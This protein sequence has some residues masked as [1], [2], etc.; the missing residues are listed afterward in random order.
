MRAADPVYR[1]RRFGWVLTR[2]DDIAWALRAPHLSAHRPLPDEPVPQPL[3][4]I[5]DE[6]RALRRLQSLWMLYSDP[7][8]HTRLRALVGAAFTP[9]VVDG[10]RTRIQAIVDGLIDA[11]EPTGQ[12]D[13]IADLAYPL[14]TT[15]IAD[16]LGLPTADRARFK[17]WSDDIAAGFFLI[18]G[19]E[20]AAAV[21]RAYESQNALA[22]YFRELVAERRAHP[23]D[24]LL[25]AL[26]AAEA[27]GAMLGE[28]ELLATCVLL[29]F[30]G[31]E[32]TTNL[33]GNGVLALLEHADQFERLR[34]E[35]ALLGSAVEEFLRYDGPVQATAR[36]ATVGFELHGTRVDPGDYLLLVLGA[37][38]HDPAQFAEPDRLDLGRADNRHLAF[39]LGPHFCLGAA[40]A[41]LEA[42]VAFETLLRRLPRLRAG[43]APPVRRPDFFLR[44][45]ASLP[46]A[47]GS[48][49]GA[50]PPR[51]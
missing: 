19:R 51:G 42:Y 43:P 24:D 15:V 13:V 34:Q 46:V 33:I 22:T 3:A 25:S 9:R 1:E 23:R 36:R 27:D 12:M 16:L 44:G 4:A 29:L 20:T 2:Y 28:D 32:T 30:A 18:V 41:R 31:H 47:F 45:L 8:Q 14:P 10:M 50:N 38:N 5:A 7:P 48:P 37:A 40:L 39:S 6:V 35:R 21:R 49:D 11:V 26:V 17:Q